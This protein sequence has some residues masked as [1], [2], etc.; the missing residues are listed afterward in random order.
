MKLSVNLRE[1]VIENAG[2]EEVRIFMEGA[3]DLV[4][5]CPS[6]PLSLFFSLSPSSF[7]YSLFLDS[8]FI[9]L[10]LY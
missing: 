10:L 4:C 6:L 5:T 2:K 8:F 1:E 3:F 9:Y 7:P